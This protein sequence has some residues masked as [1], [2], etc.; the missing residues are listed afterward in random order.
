MEAA[1]SGMESYCNDNPKATI[2]QEAG[3][4]ASQESLTVKVACPIM[5]ERRFLCPMP[6][7]TRWCTGLILMGPTYRIWRGVGAKLPMVMCPGQRPSGGGARVSD[8]CISLM[9]PARCL[10]I[11]SRRSP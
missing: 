5:K 2:A 7:G 11:A 1:S 8:I 4:R 6:K 9:G 3:A 10:E